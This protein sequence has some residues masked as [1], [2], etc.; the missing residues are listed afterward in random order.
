MLAELSDSGFLF[1]LA[2]ATRV[3]KS[4][5]ENIITIWLLFAGRSE[6]GPVLPEA[7]KSA[8]FPPI[9]V[10]QKLHAGMNNPTL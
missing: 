10:A 4:V 1:M 9:P 7:S 5:E 2:F 6:K 8:Q 3:A